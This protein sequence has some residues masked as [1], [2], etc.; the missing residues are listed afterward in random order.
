MR[1]LFCLFIV[2]SMVSA[3]F[4]QDAAK[5]YEKGKKHQ[6]KKD[7]EGA[8]EWYSKAI[9][10]D[11]G[12]ADAYCARGV[13]R[14]KLG[15]YFGQYTDCST[16]ISLRPEYAEACLYRGIAAIYLRDNSCG[17]TFR[18]DNF[19]IQ[20]PKNKTVKNSADT[21]VNKRN[22]VV[23][24]TRTTDV[25]DFGYRKA[26]EDFDKAISINPGYAEA[27]YYRGVACKKSG[28]LD[29]ACPDFQKAAEL[30]FKQA[31]EDL[32]EYCR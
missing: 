25:S 15:N 2:L 16:A 27:W 18:S 3:G 22:V 8:S 19:T 5:F 31:E 7:Y 12:Y 17:L 10:A 6:L 23:I 26:I 4:G 24:N 29:L 11:P 32:K 13:S 21:T 20:D 30:G 9:K 14:G 1:K 28:R